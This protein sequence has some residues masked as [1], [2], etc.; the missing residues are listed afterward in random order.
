MT[1]KSL[2]LFALAFIYSN[3]VHA[4]IVINN[5]DESVIIEQSTAITNETWQS[6]H[7]I[8][9][10]GTAFND[11]FMY[12]L[13]NL[14]IAGEFHGNLWG[15]GYS[16]NYIGN[17]DN[18][19]RFAALNNVI[20]EGEIQKNLI[21]I[22]PNVNGATIKLSD[23]SEVFGSAWLFGDNVILEGKIGD[24]TIHANKVTIGGVISG[25]LEI[26]A[27]DI[28]VLHNAKID[29]NIEYR[30]DN[31]FFAPSSAQ[32]GGEIR[33]IPAPIVEKESPI[34]TNLY[35]LLAA[36]I[37]AVPFLKLFQNYAG[38]SAAAFRFHPWRCLFTGLIAMFVVPIFSISLCSSFIG[39]PLGL[40]ILAIYI[41]LAYLSK[42]LL[43]LII[44]LIFFRQLKLKAPK[45]AELPC[46][47]GLLIFFVIDM[48]PFLSGPINFAVLLY[49][50]GALILALFN[51]MK[52]VIPVNKQK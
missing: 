28:V 39:L 23:Q 31:E 27:N 8:K 47:L 15:A 4:K 41:I 26:I 49:G 1:K 11:Q 10:D 36:I 6:A 18:N 38:L 13:K 48:V 21:A 7:S 52:I 44:G 30:S 24:A 33:V 37:V 43:A 50:S 16:I 20:L 12:V 29:G 9:F 19:V 32:I 17:A 42:I 2:I 22:V 3:I 5:S 34:L 46:I 35:L 14:D 51:K 40:I 25:D 45:N